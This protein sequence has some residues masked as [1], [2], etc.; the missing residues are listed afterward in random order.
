MER[1]NFAAR[2]AR[3]SAEHWKTAV[4]AWVAFVAVAI[5]GL[6]ESWLGLRRRLAPQGVSIDG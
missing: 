2:A 5:V 6:L 3:W 1:Y 4:A